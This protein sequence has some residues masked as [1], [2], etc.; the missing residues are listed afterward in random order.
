MPRAVAL[1]PGGP[2]TTAGERLGDR[3]MPGGQR[4]LGPANGA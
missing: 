3:H 1:K 4:P 2:T